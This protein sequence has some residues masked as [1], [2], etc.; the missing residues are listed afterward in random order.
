MLPLI[1]TRLF[2]PLNHLASVVGARRSSL[3]RALIAVGLAGVSATALQGQTTWDGGG[4]NSNWSTAANWNANIAPGNPSNSVLHFGGTLRL[5]PNVDS[6]WTVNG[7]AFDTG[8]GA[9]VIGGSTLTIGSSGV[10]N[11]GGSL[12]TINNTII[13]NAA[14]AFQTT[15]TGNL[16]LGGNVTNGG[17]LV[18]ANATSGTV[19]TLSGTLSGSGGVAK[20]GAGTLLLSGNNSYTGTTTINAGTVK[21]GATGSGGNGPLGTTGSGTV[22][23]FGGALDLNGFT[24]TN[25][26]PLS[27]SGS[28]VNSTGALTN[29]SAT[30]ATFSGVTTLAGN[31][32]IGGTGN[33]TLSAGLTDGGSAR[34]LTKTGADTL[35]LNAAAGTWTSN[36]SVVINGGTLQ[37]GITNALGSSALSNLTVNATTAGT[38][39]NFALGNS[40]AQSIA[41]LTFGGTG[42]TNTSTNNVSIGTSST[43]TLGGNVTYDATNNPLGAT[44]SG[45]TLG[46]GAATRTFAIADS[47]NAAK[48]LSVSSVISG[49]GGLTKTG[50]GTLSLSG[51]NT[52][53]G[54]T[55]INGGTL[56][57]TSM[58]GLGTSGT[59][60]SNLV[61]DGGA[62]QYTGA[63]ASSSRL[64]TMGTGGATIDSSGSGALTLSSTST[65]ATSG[66]GTRMLTLTGSNTSTNVLFG[67]ITDG[68]GGATSVTKSGSGTWLYDGSGA[69]TYTGDT[70]ITGGI[71]QLSKKSGR[72]ATGTGNIYVGN[73]SATATLAYTDT[74]NQL[75]NN[76]SILISDSGTFDTNGYSDGIGMIGDG[77]SVSLK[78]GRVLLSG[79]G[80]NSTLTLTATTGTT[81]FSGVIS[82]AGSLVKNGAST[83]S[84]AGANTFT[85][86]TT[87]SAGTLNLNSAAALGTGALTISAGTIDNTSGSAITLNNNA[88]NWN[89][90]FTF[91]GTNDLNLGTGAIAMNSSRILTVD[92]GTL[93]VGGAVSG[94]GAAL[95]KSGAGTLNLSGANT[96]SG[97]TTIS[98]GTLSV[99]RS[100]PSGAAG[101]LGNA[102]AAVVI[103]DASTGTNNTAL[104]ISASGASVGRNLTVANSGTGVTTLGGDDS[105]TTGTGSFT[106]NIA[107]NRSVTLDAAGSSAI[108]FGTGVISGAGGIT[109]TG[110]GSV[111]LS[112]TNT[113]TGMSTVSQGTLSIGSNAPSGLGGAL[114]NSSSAIVVNDASTG[115]SDTGLTIATSGVS[116]D[117]A[118]TVANNGTGVTTLGGDTSLT[119]GTGTYKGNIT[120]NRSASLQ[121]SGTSNII[122]STGAISGSGAINKI[123]T[124]TVTL[125]GTNTF[126]GGVTVSAGTLSASGT[127]NLG[128]FAALGNYSGLSGPTDVVTVNSGTTLAVQSSYTGDVGNGSTNSFQ[129]LVLNGS[130]VGGG[131]ALRSLGGNSTW[132]GNTVLGSDATIT[133]SAAAGNA[134]ELF[135]GAFVANTA[136]NVSLNNHTLTINGPG[137]T[138][139]T[140]KVGSG[141]G[142]TGSVIINGGTSNTIV[143][144]AGYANYYTGSTTV[145]SGQLYLGIQPSGP[146]NSAVLG[147]LTIGSGSATTTATVTDGYLAQIADT[148]KVTINSDGTLDLATANVLEVIGS[149]VLNGG[150][151]TTGT[152]ELHIANGAG[153]VS[154]TSATTSTI[155]GKFRFL[156]TDGTIDVA[157]G[158]TL[159][160]SADL[161]GTNIF[162]TGSGKMI[163]TFNN[164]SNGY[165]G[166]TNVV[167]GTLNIRN[168]GALGALSSGTIVSNG[169]TLQLENTA[170]NVQVGAEALTLNGAG[171]A[172]QGALNSV[173]GADNRYGGAITLGSDSTIK[174]DAGNFTVNGSI[175]GTAAAAAVQTVTVG[176]AANTE[177]HGAIM[178]GSGGGTVALSKIDSGTLTLTGASTF[179]GAVAISAGTVSIT[180]DN[181]LGSQTN[182]VSVAS[183]ATLAL[184]GGN[185]YSN[186]IGKLTGAGLVS[187]AGS[188]N[189]KVNTTSA[190]TFDGRLTGTG[191]F[192]KSGAG[193]FTF[194]STSNTSAFNFAGTVK[195]TATLT[196]DTLEFK[197]GLSTN[198][199]SI[200]TLDL[201][202]GTLLLTNS[203][204]NVGTLN[205]TGNSILD[206]GT[207]GASTLNATNIYIAA[208]AILTIKN[209]NSEV[210]FLFAN[211]DFRLDSAT[212]TVAV[213]DAVGSQPEN[214][215][216]FQG[217]PQSPTGAYTTWIDNTTNYPTYANYE[218]RPVPEPATYGALLLGGCLGFLGWIRIKRNRI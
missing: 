12:Q 43:L 126:T 202:G 169:A 122:F 119:S 140:S 85:G 188:T 62:L 208:G 193:T 4:A 19:V 77:T 206:F 3:R 148:S 186:T 51:S 59:A 95:T 48:D 100:A 135:I 128:G 82:G 127:T 133:N 42:A 139:F 196:S 143:T 161:F 190:D 1:L 52:Y 80:G 46:L 64:F 56:S 24:L 129:N 36:N 60:A 180:V 113:Y 94:S 207:A 81:Q 200:G 178:N 68:T 54:A 158:S 105:L 41:S 7:L 66:S 157:S 98:Q 93:T 6:N 74:A 61:L 26:E 125:S 72:N 156:A 205:I 154:V 121:A 45:G 47:T 204:I 50:T 145:N 134:N 179:T 171:Y 30:A 33:I 31:T 183:G 212:G 58:A 96:Y 14:E 90:N 75:A 164:Q 194:S 185:G 79:T 116:V 91:T 89:G 103:N 199:L 136:S 176:G 214:H 101:A 197:G 53:S 69:N 217:D 150:N 106:G 211:S 37:A 55:T 174:T 29:S 167:G 177:L 112:G 173:A 198:A 123:D 87:L 182:A 97:T 130:G 78:T 166:V 159:M 83:L 151:V 40:V 65:I 153:N 22:V 20:N 57:I 104:T 209:W 184:S 144:Y 201:T 215:V 76:S 67:V 168:S 88:Q 8:A 38:T 25:A 21:I 115:S 132:T 165:T 23:N 108:T 155:A 114:G 203:I 16:T 63:T 218:I 27:I 131:G 70:T 111:I 146:A 149:L 109:K 5:T 163:S 187:I 210:D 172:S 162:K 181:T 152:G 15:S 189:L 160:M 213:R 120:L 102:S 110:S 39:A 10:S 107:L 44:I 117:R 13:M 84:L 71:L 49:T 17:F 86:G 175:T 2:S 124:G 118:V 32:T 35:L 92:G 99:G 18:T 138:Y 142:D 34:T 191:L 73:G 9:F 216:Y 192:E 170:G 141:A 147:D 195:L 11:D 28:G 137:N